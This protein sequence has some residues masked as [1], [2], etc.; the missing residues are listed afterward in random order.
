MTW[1]EVDLTKQLWI[2]PKERMKAGKEHRVPLPER[3]CEILR[4]L[5]PFAESAKSVVFIGPKGGPMS[6]MAM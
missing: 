4:E 2:V 5:E 1:A 3:A 6:N